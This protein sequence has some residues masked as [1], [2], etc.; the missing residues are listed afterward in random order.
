MKKYAISDPKT[1]ELV[2]HILEDLNVHQE[3]L[4]VQNE[5]LFSTQSS[6]EQ[7]KDKYRQLFDHAPVGLVSLD[8][9]GRIEELNLTASLML[10]YPRDKAI[11]H[12]FRL[13]IAD[14]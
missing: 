6:L 12:L 2:H 4:R 9:R 11:S 5:E 8:E 3:E 13:L 7:A 1:L 10:D 14:P